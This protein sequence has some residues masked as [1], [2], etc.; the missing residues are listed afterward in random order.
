MKIVFKY[1][2]WG[3]TIKVVCYKDGEEE[4]SSSVRV[5]RWDWL[6]KI[7]IGWTKRRMMSYILA[8]DKAMRDADKAWK[9]TEKFLRELEMEERS[10]GK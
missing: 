8:L 7:K 1:E 2:A 3:D 9:R 5:S 10:R 6:T 4:F